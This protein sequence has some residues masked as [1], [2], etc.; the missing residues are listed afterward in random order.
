MQ[1]KEKKQ[2]S[3]RHMRTQGERERER[4]GKRGISREG[5]KDRV[6]KKDEELYEIHMANVKPI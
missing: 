4:T 1:E 3:W 2:K 5:K 6:K